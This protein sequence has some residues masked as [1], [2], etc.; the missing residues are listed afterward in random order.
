MGWTANDNREPLATNFATRFLT[1]GVFD[2]T[3]LTAWR[4]SKIEVNE[5]ACG[6]IPWP[7]PLD[8]EQLVVFDEAEN[9]DVYVPPPFFPPPPQISLLPFPWTAGAVDV[10]GPAFPVPYYFGWLY[11]NLNTTVSGNPNPPEDPAAAQAWVTALH[12]A[13]GRFSVGL[14]AMQLDNATNASHATVGP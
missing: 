7:Y 10:G 12:S 6:T 5:F 11:L 9:P 13:L 4:D 14:P 2:G 3:R 1:G 8:Q